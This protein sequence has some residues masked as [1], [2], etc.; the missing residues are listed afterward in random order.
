VGDFAGWAPVMTQHT[1]NGRGGQ[2]E[3]PFPDHLGLAMRAL[4]P[5]CRG[6]DDPL[7]PQ[8]TGSFSYFYF[9]TALYKTL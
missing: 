2:D 9:D 7:L 5:T 8:V 4:R 1:A 3:T 6:L